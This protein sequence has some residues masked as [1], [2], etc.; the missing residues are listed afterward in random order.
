MKSIELKKVAHDCKVGRP[1][2]ELAPNIFED[3][4]F[5]DEKGNVIGFYLRQVTG[6][7]PKFAAIANAEFRSKRVPKS[8]MRR[9]SGV[10]NAE[11]ECK[12]YSTLLGSIPPKPLMKRSYANTSSVHRHESA[13]TFCK[14]ML[15]LCA[16]C[17]SL[18]QEITPAI[19]QRQFDMV[20]ESVMPKYRFGSLFTSSISNYN[21]AAS[22]HQDTA[23]QKETV[24]AIYTKRY[25][26]IGGNL[27]LPD[28]DA[29]I[30]CRD[31]SL[32]VYPAWRN[33]HGVT[34]VQAASKDGYRN[35]LVFYPLKHFFNAR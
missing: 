23:N 29:T 26:S 31:D 33:L 32:I 4:L 35:S 19:Y 10:N 15:K 12:Q 22:Y 9:A 8:E 14:A 28:Y 18:I 24:N 21:I 2:K 25:A 5:L 6:M 17:E 1:A 20:A 34:P 13:K 7:A 16:S 11:N 27:H 3:S 30:D